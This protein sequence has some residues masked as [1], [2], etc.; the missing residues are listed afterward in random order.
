M[1]DSFTTC[2]QLD[3]PRNCGG[4]A[5]VP[6]A[7]PHGVTL[8]T[9]DT[10]GAR[11]K[12]PHLDSKLS[13]TLAKTDWPTLTP[14]SLLRQPLNCGVVG[15]RPSPW[16]GG[17]APHISAADNIASADA[18]TWIIIGAAIILGLLL[19]RR[20]RKKLVIFLTAAAVLSA[21]HSGND[22]FFWASGF[23]LIA[24]WTIRQFKRGV[25]PRYVRIVPAK[26]PSA[27]KLPG[28]FPW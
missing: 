16:P 7:R 22:E 20:G 23:G 19:W 15:T 3:L 5:T 25:E 1:R 21:W 10:S 18:G 11:L 24:L 28:A 2:R 6:T 4:T 26:S 17:S 8:A 13:S 14:C 9:L 27:I 12:P